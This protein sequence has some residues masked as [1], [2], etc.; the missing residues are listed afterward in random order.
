MP[1]DITYLFNK[2][3]RIIKDNQKFLI[4][5]HDFPDGD[6]LGSQVALY[7]LLKALRKDVF[8]VCDSGIPYQYKFL[9]S[10]DDLKKDIHDIKTECNKK[11]FICFCLDSADEGRFSIDINEIRQKTAL[12]INIDHHLGNTMYGD[13]DIVDS[14]KSATAEILYELIISGFPELLDY[15]ISLGIYAAIL[16]DTGRFQYSN[17]THEVHKIVSHLLE[18]G[19][20]PS[21]V[22][23]HIYENEPFKRF[24]LLEK[25]LKRIRIIRSKKLILSY[26]LK[27]DF[28]K[29]GLPFSANDGIIE[30]LRSASDA[31]IAALL[32]QVG[33]NQYKVSLRSSD[34]GYNVVDVAAKFGGGGHKM[35]SAYS[36]KGNLKD[37][38]ASLIAAIN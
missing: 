6:C 34:P 13:I 28:E 16:T 2:T 18:F 4:I 14:S 21:D 8:M 33:R 7:G 38:I 29:L 1:Q 30:I 11:D 20:V 15:N 26:V 24:K 3:I 22:F 23:A 32:K 25:V 37:V 31:K 27:S 10:I 17:T 5:T 9:P 19:I 35:A 36:R 12:I